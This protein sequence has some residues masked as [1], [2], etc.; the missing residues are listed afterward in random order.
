MEYDYIFDSSDTRYEKKFAIDYEKN[1]PVTVFFVKENIVLRADREGN[2]LFCDTGGNALYRGKADRKRQYF[3]EIYCSVRAG[4][5]S[6]SFPIIELIDH[7]PNC[8]GEYD[9]WSEVIREKICIT[10]PAG[11]ASNA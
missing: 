11:E 5:V 10:Y 1:L 8:D 9:R 7:Y 3:G 6:V 4:A 2:A